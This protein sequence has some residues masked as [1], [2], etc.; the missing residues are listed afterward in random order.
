MA[1]KS[2]T[3]KD[4]LTRILETHPCTPEPVS[5]EYIQLLVDECLDKNKVGR[6][7]KYDPEKHL[8]IVMKSSSEG[9]DLATIAVDLQV[10][11]STFQLWCKEHPEFS[12]AVKFGQKLAKSW[13]TETGRKNLQND[14]F[15]NTLYMMNMQN[16]FGWTRKLDASVRKEEHIINE[17]RKT[18]IIKVQKD[19]D[20]AE[21][22][23]ILLE[24]DAI[25]L[26]YKTEVN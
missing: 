26:P 6:P 13:W 1:K 25:E 14:R 7:T 24:N 16:R 3:K 22:L 21:V 8:P 10:A 19:E 2:S 5:E 20:T 11:W 17:E 23:K 12:A 15:N 18:T 9:K 4:S